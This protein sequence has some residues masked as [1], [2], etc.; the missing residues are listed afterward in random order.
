MS[1]N[2]GKLEALAGEHTGFAGAVAVAEFVRSA[3]SSLKAMRERAGLTQIELGD[4]LGLS[5]GRISQIESGLMD[6]A[7]NLETIALYANACGEDVAIEASGEEPAYASQPIFSVYAKGPA[8]DFAHSQLEL[9][10]NRAAIRAAMIEHSG[11]MQIKGAANR[12]R[13]GAP[14]AASVMNVMGLTRR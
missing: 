12:F 2:L 14:L 7:P 11:V 9:V 8:F 3:A 6:H 1:R 10:S 13:L 4:Q 5:Q